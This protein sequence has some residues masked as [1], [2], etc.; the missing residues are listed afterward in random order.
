MKNLLKY[1][2]PGNY[3]FGYETPRRGIFQEKAGAGERIPWGIVR[4]GPAKFGVFQEY[5]EGSWQAV[6]Y[7]QFGAIERYRPGVSGNWPITTDDIPASMISPAMFGL[8]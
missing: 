7:G 6:C 2:N 4:E 5:G 1:G 3:H 8:E